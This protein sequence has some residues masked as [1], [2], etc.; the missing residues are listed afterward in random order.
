MNFYQ[1]VLTCTI[2]LTTLVHA[3]IIID[4]GYELA[5]RG[6]KKS[7]KPLEYT[8]MNYEDFYGV[9]L[10]I[11]SPE[12]TVGVALDLLTA[13]IFVPSSNNSY[14]NKKVDSSG[15]IFNCTGGTFDTTA[16]STY[17]RNSSDPFYNTYRIT[18]YASGYYAMDTFN[19]NGVNVTNVSFAVADAS[20]YTYGV[21]GLGLPAG[22]G[23]NLFELSSYNDVLHEYVNLPQILKNNKYT[24]SAVFSLF[25]NDQCGEG[26][27][28][29]F[30][31][32][33][34]SKYLGKLY[35]VP[36][37]NVYKNAGYKTPR[38]YDIGLYGIGAYTDSN[39][40][41]TFSTTLFSASLDTTSDF[42]YFYKTIAD[43]MASYVG[44]TWDTNYS[45]Y[46]LSC[47]SINYNTSFVYDFGGFNIFVPMSNMAFVADAKNDTC[48]LG[49]KYHHMN[50]AILGTPLLS[51]AY[52]V[53]DQDN[54]EVSIGVA[55]FKGAQVSSIQSVGKK[56]PKAT[57][58]PSYSNSW[59][60]APSNITLGGNMFT[61]TKSFSNPWTLTDD[62]GCAKITESS[63]SVLNNGRVEQ[64]ITSS[65]TNK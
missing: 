37:V 21:M 18:D 33:D 20:N 9:N 59:T 6:S 50:S 13:D 3:S 45:L 38:R 5:K 30:G 32:V 26:G 23:S 25:L 17:F 10:N 42:S 43:K 14:C 57:K 29:L 8:I 54:Y 49:F 44:A 62:L 27:K 63:G 39:N 35:T 46:T 64:Q 11:G 12:Q 41:E 7:S 53:F 55:N 4:K 58:A 52:L 47:A 1:T 40:N 22:E 60:S 36:V 48:Y 19:I 2:L 34:H 61:N 16:S 56:I 15:D 31:A 51:S 24:K 28:L 65:T